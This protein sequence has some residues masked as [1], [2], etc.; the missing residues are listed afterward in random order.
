[1]KI[2]EGTVQLDSQRRY[3]ETRQSEVLRSTSFRN[4]LQAAGATSPVA[5]ASSASAAAAKGD[6]QEELTRV[7]LLLQQLVDTILQLL[8]GEKCRCGVDDLAELKK[9]LPAANGRGIGGKGGD[10]GEV[11][12]RPV[13]E[14]EWE[15]RTSERIEEHER[16]EVSAN[17]V[18]KTADGRE[19][20]FDLDLSMCRDYVCMRESVDGGKVVFKD[21]LV[22]NFDASA[23]EL[24]DRRFSFDLDADGSAE[25]VATLG[26]G[27]GYLA[28]DRNGDSKIN[29]GSELFGAVGEHAGDGFADLAG[30]DADGNGWLDEADPAFAALGVWFPDGKIQPLKEAGIGALGLA[31]VDSQFTLKEAADGNDT[32]R[33]QI[34]MGC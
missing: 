18:V 23:A 26:A 22:I 32:P 3:S 8:S 11:G 7:R 33:G 31:S 29:N 16:T 6:P 10:G 19:I 27:S 4:I 25:S 30:L 24:S 34:R 17:G 28:F 2:E 12:G 15:T 9:G 21:P 20:R 13:A 5:G 1:M 14:F